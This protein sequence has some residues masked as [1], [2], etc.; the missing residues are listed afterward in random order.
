MFTRKPDAFKIFT[1]LH[2]FSH[3]NHSTHAFDVCMRVSLS[4]TGY[5]VFIALSSP[6]LRQ[7]GA[8]PV[9]LSLRLIHF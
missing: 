1:P 7:A 3:I 5:C 2:S 6:S 9:L 8:H 4:A